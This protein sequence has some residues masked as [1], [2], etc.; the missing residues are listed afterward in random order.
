MNQ[1]IQIDGD[2]RFSAF[3]IETE[4]LGVLIPNNGGKFEWK[5]AWIFGIY[6]E[7]LHK[8]KMLVN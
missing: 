3:I 4:F 5:F 7:I 1:Y 6:T 8:L 2:S